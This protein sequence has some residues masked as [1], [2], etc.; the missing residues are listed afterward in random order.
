MVQ[1]QNDNQP[2]TQIT[3]IES[4][5]DKQAEA[6]SVMKERACSLKLVSAIARGRRWLGEIISG[7]VTDAEEIASREPSAKST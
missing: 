7:T 4:K 3:I 1:I 2:V 6:L 5:P